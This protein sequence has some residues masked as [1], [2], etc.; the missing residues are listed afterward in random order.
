MPATVK[1]VP[2]RKP[3]TYMIGK[4]LLVAAPPL[5]R[6]DEG[7]RPHSCFCVF[8]SDLVS[9]IDMRMV[10]KDKARPSRTIHL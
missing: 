5:P 2:R 6:G 1:A 10:T 8:G 9:I 3:M 4:K 7:T